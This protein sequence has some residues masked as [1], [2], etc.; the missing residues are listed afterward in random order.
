MDRDLLRRYGLQ[1]ESLVHDIL[2]VDIEPSPQDAT[3]IYSLLH[4]HSHGFAFADASAHQ[5]ALRCIQWGA[6]HS[7]PRLS[8]I[9]FRPIPA[10][11]D[12][13]RIDDAA[14]VLD[15]EQKGFL[16]VHNGEDWIGTVEANAISDALRYNLGHVNISLIAGE[17]PLLIDIDAP[18]TLARELIRRS[19][20]SV[21]IVMDQGKTCLLYTSP[22]PRD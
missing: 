18:I 9:T 10:V 12:T 6:S 1:L 8:E 4:V 22:S 16:A 17:A 5:A 11:I 3:D 7:P 2:A 20:A 14:K 15:L 21:L 19:T 13:T